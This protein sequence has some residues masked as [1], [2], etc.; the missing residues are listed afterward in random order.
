MPLLQVNDLH[1]SI[2][3]RNG[4]ARPV[5]GVSFSIEPGQ[6]LAIVGESG[7]GKSMTALSLLQLV[8]EP[9]GYIE[10]GSVT[11]EGRDLLGLTWEEMRPLRGRDIAM[12][13]QEPM[14]SLNPTLTVGQQIVEAMTVHATAHGKEAHRRAIDALQRVG[15]KD[16]A[17]RQYPHELSGGM[18]QRVMIA[19]AL[20]NGPKLLIADE[21]TTAL[22]V[23]VQ[24]QILALIRQLQRETGMSVLLITHDLGT[25]AEVADQVAVMYAG[26]IVE[27]SPVHE[28]F[29]RPLHPYTQGLFAS[30]PARS[31]RG[32]DLATLEGRVP[33]S[34]AWPLACRFEGRCPHRFGSCSQIAPKFQPTEAPHPSRCH[35]YDPEIDRPMRGTPR[36]AQEQAHELI[37]GGIAS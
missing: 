19:M 21:P 8:P 5:D 1:T 34:T 12:I 9:A 35:L 2:R 14:T 31:R 36:A 23:T 22:D 11:F 18:R 3:T 28:M 15:L 33:E 27:N 17:M 24:A 26:Q 10:S 7:C 20:V 32:H 25:V 29:A 13:F 16:S 37:E 30:L 6:T 4:I